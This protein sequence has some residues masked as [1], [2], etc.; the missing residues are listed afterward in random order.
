VISDELPEA[1][2]LFGAA[3]GTY[4]DPDDLR[5]LVDAALADRAGARARAAD[6]RQAVLAAHTFDHRARRLLELLERYGLGL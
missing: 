6:G 5:R 2:A 1:G 4:R 3:V